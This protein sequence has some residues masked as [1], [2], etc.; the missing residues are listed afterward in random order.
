MPG[1]EFLGLRAQLV[2]VET[3]VAHHHES[4]RVVVKKKK[5]PGIQHKI[6][7]RFHGWLHA[8]SATQTLDYQS[9][10]LEEQLVGINAKTA[11]YRAVRSLSG[12]VSSGGP[13]I[14]FSYRSVNEP[15]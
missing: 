2:A 4:R 1:T 14:E 3:F 10:P 7:P 5:M 6:A 8:K 9:L 11:P 15:R 12:R 13:S